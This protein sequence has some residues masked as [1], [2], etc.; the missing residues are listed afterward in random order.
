MKIQ[1]L[2]STILLLSLATIPS[3]FAASDSA[4]QLCTGRLPV[5]RTI[6]NN[7]G[8]L[9]AIIDPTVGSLSTALTPAFKIT[10]NS[11]GAQTLDLTA[12]CEGGST[13]EA[14]YNRLGTRY[15]IL[16]NS[17]VPPS[18]GAIADCKNTS[19]TAGANANAISWAVTEPTSTAELSYVYDNSL[20]GWKGTLTHKNDTLT[21]LTI[22]ATAPFAG[23]F[24][25]DDADGSYLASVTLSFN[26]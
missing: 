20:P 1:I 10:T 18:N 6:I 9:T 16:A 19:P 14:I 12:K 13:Q 23:T 21:N 11:S 4:T 7:G 8:N 5:S 25:I 22:P 15:I 24:S 17:T 3:A 2:L 26:P